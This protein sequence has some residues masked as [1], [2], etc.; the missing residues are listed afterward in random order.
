MFVRSLQVNGCVLVC[1]G[2]HGRSCWLES[3]LIGREGLEGH[4]EGDGQVEGW[5]V[6]L[7]R[8]FS[9]CEVIS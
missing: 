4:R 1:S 6:N 8:K 3:D 2:V 7:V 5:F 9:A